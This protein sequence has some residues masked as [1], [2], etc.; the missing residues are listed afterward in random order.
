MLSGP[1]GLGEARSAVKSVGRASVLYDSRRN[2]PGQALTADVAHAIVYVMTRIESY[3]PESWRPNQLAYSQMILAVVQK[4]GDHRIGLEGPCGCGKS[5]GY[6]RAA[7]DPRCPPAVVLSTTRQHLQQIE[8]TLQAHWPGGDW[9][10]LRGRS[11]YGCCDAPAGGRKIDDQDPDAS[12]EHVG[13]TCPRGEGCLY[14]AAVLRC[15][16][17]KVVVQCTIGHLYRKQFWAES[18]PATSK[19]PALAQAR[20]SVVDREVIILDEAHEYVKVRRSFETTTLGMYAR[21]WLRAQTQ[22]VLQA[23]RLQ[24]RSS[25]R[26]GYVVLTDPKNAHLVTAVRADLAKVLDNV[27]KALDQAE[28]ER[29]TKRLQTQQKKLQDRLA[30]LDAIGGDSHRCVSLQ[31][32]GDFIDMVAEP[33]RSYT[34]EKLARVE[35]FTSATLAP[36][37]RLLH[38]EDQWVKLFPEIFD[39][40]GKVR[41]MPLPDQGEPGS[42]ANVALD[43]D[44]IEALYDQPGRPFTLALAFS[45]AHAATMTAKIKGQPSVYIQ[46]EDTEESL[47]QLVDRAK[48]AAGSTPA[49]FLVTYGGWVG[50]DVPGNKWLIIGSVPKSPL[51]AAVESRAAANRTS[52]WCD[53]ERNAL[54]R[55]Q[56]AQ[57]LGRALRTAE[58]QAV[59]IWQNNQ[60]ARDAG[61]NPSTGRMA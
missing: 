23:A 49:P 36:V 4:P 17:A 40:A 60:A 29:S 57:G 1:F 56:L 18:D 52:P 54:D 45:R 8:A 50:V 16:A 31:F 20:R 33:A 26:A 19:D 34:Q 25:Y 9:A 6:L 51:S 61:I 10:V 55:L 24:P 43:A 2:R 13:T 30:I 53:Y 14:R 47:G 59:L 15:G 32:N 38:I 5:I 28:D 11:H 58:D 39:W 3:A 44:T 35:V 21:T 46:G 22:S 37:A 7:M 27:N 41:L 12:A 42:K 48:A